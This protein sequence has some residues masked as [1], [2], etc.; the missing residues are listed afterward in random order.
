MKQ[1]LSLTLALALCAALFTGCGCAANVST[2]PGGMIT[3][4][5][6]EPSIMPHPT[7]THE[8]RPRETTRPTEPHG[9]TL[10]RPSDPAASGPM[11]TEGGE[12]SS[13][14]TDTA[15]NRNAMR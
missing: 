1:I 4:D 11:S 10:P 15:G 12:A 13:T 6:R 2:H 3:E 5:T 7:A 9:T 14:P 8:T